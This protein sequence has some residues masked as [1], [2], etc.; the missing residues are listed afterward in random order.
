MNDEQVRLEC[1][2]IAVSAAGNPDKIAFAQQLYDWVRAGK[3]DS[4]KS[5]LR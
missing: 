2:K 4:K 3:V 5:Q 1:L